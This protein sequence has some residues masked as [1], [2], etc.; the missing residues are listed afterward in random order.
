MI[1]KILIQMMP[2]HKCLQIKILLKVKKI[3]KIE[4]KACLE[5]IGI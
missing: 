4:C 2:S 5:T 3:M 1:T